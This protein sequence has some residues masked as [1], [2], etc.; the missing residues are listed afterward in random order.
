MISKL[1]L[2]EYITRSSPLSLQEIK[3]VAIVNLFFYVSDFLRLH[4]MSFKFG[5]ILLRYSS[6]D[7]VLSYHRYFHIQYN[8]YS[9]NYLLLLVYNNLFLHA[10]FLFLIA[11]FFFNLKRFFTSLI[12]V[13][14]I[15][16]FS[17]KRFFL[18]LIKLSSIF[19]SFTSLELFIIICCEK[20]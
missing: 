10:L 6:T 17:L 7:S 1:S 3:S 9:K 11:L 2:F 16:F 18:S 14:Y 5:L 13:S 4:M 15:Y 8:Y 20:N 12:I 19:L